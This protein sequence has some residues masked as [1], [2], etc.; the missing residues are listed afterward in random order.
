MRACAKGGK[1]SR[2]QDVGGDAEVPRFAKPRTE[3][4]LLDIGVEYWVVLCGTRRPAHHD[5][6]GLLPN[7]CI[8]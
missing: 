2:K 4:L 3:T 7:Q 1:G 5:L 8:Q 6:C